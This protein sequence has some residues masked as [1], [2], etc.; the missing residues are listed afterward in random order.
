LIQKK[1]LIRIEIFY[2]L[3]L[4]CLSQTLSI[5]G[6]TLFISNGNYIVLPTSE[7]RLQIGDFNKEGVIFNLDSYTGKWKY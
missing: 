3:R 1:P 2:F 7:P 4:L 6:D 5:S